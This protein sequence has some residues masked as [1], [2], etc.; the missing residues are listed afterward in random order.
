MQCTAQALVFLAKDGS[1]AA[2]NELAQE[3]QDA[4][5]SGA[6]RLQ[7]SFHDFSI[8]FLLT[9]HDPAEA[10]KVEGIIF[11]LDGTLIDFEGLLST[12]DVCL[13]PLRCLSLGP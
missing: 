3:K 12:M 9:F 2:N 5:E 10:R 13:A 7:G 6:V 4:A 1:F 8:N 11:D